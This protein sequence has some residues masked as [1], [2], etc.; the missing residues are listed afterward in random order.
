MT[1]T[2]LSRRTDRYRR[3]FPVGASK[4]VGA[5]DHTSAPR[6]D[7]EDDTNSVPIFASPVTKSEDFRDTGGLNTQELRPEETGR[8]N[9]T[10]HAFQS[11][12][13]TK[14]SKELLRT[15]AD[16]AWQLLSSYLDSKVGIPQD[17]QPFVHRERKTAPDDDLLSDLFDT[18]DEEEAKH[19][20]E[21]DV[22]T[23]SEDTAKTEHRTITFRWCQV[24]PT[25]TH[26]R[27]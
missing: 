17:D 14:H 1:P 18:S 6:P 20:I 27:R 12:K 11:P 24:A 22:N 19:P 13:D 25:A 26:R 16:S 10:G 5:A 23:H 7:L 9:N 4:S 15:I 2:V 8:T 21:N 3:I